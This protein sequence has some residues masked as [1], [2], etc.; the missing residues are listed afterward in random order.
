MKHITQANNALKTLYLGVLRDNINNTTDYTFRNIKQATTDVWGKDIIALVEEDGKYL[1][2]KSELESIFFTIEISDK[3]I[4]ASEN[5]T[6]AFV[7]LLNAEMERLIKISDN[8]LSKLLFQQKENA[9]TFDDFGNSIESTYINSITDVLDSTKEAVFGVNRKDYKLLQPQEKST[10][11]L[12][13]KEL[14]SYLF[15][16]EALD[17]KTDVIVCS[18]NTLKDIKQDYLD[19]DKGIVYKD[20][21]ML[22]EN[23]PIVSNKH[24]DYDKIY[25]LNLKEF[26]LHQ[27][28]D[29]QWLENEDGNVIRQEPNSPYYKATLVKYANLICKDI[30]KQGV[31]TIKLD[32]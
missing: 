22:I 8:K 4:R 2:L 20:G 14:K 15:E 17:C 7:N 11:N 6:G 25:F 28:S 30:S 19:N 29:W 23:T 18:P 16:L 13:E 5:N 3:A 27:L 21:I 1:Q 9:Y 32:K 31:L 24:I 12:S 26:A 10:Y